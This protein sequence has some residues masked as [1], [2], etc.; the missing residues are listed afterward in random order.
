MSAYNAEKYV[1]EAIESI[2]SQTFSDFEFVIIDDGCTDGTSEVLRSFRDNRILLVKNDKNIGLTKS[3]NRGLQLASGKYIAR[4]D[5]DDIS[6]AERFEKQ[7]EFLDAHPAVGLVGCAVEFIDPQGK[8]L[9]FHRV[10]KKRQDE[11]LTDGNWFNHS[12]TAFRR[13]CLDYVGLYREAFHYAQDYDLWLRISEKYEIAFMPEPLVKIR[14]NC[15]SISA[16]KKA[17]QK[18]YVNLALE[19]SKQRRTMGKDILEESLDRGKFD[20]DYLFKLTPESEAQMHLKTACKHYLIGEFPRAQKSFTDAIT[21]FPRLLK[22][23]ELVL[24]QIIDF[25]FSCAT[26]LD[27]R[28]GAIQFIERVFSNLPP[29]G[30]SLSRLKSKAKARVY[31]TSAFESYHIGNLSQARRNVQRAILSDP[32]WL[33]NRGVWSIFFRSLVGMRHSKQ[34]KS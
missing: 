22:D 3:L 30:E 26:G 27:S 1:G 21:H 33:R 19:L 16:Q 18:A 2:L 5:A 10:P 25:G 20:L 14:F 6:V 9:G 23:T 34:K 4:M 31:I 29:S 17:Y 28:R 24:Q 13:E 8:T 7:V 11:V 12:A 32:S 15:D